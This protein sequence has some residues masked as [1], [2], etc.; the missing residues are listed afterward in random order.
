[1]FPRLKRTAVVQN[2]HC[3][4]C[5]ALCHLVHDV[6]QHPC[7]GCNLFS[8]EDSLACPAS[9]ICPMSWQHAVCSKAALVSL[10]GPWTF[11]AALPNSCQHAPGAATAFTSYGGE[12]C[13]LPQEELASRQPEDPAVFSLLARCIQNDTTLQWQFL[14]KKLKGFRELCGKSNKAVDCGSQAAAA[15]CLSHCFHLPSISCIQPCLFKFALPHRADE[16]FR[17]AD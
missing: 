3:K 17:V 10:Q 7:E 4:Q 12:D 1:M 6:P 16:L 5:R 2:V 14:G 13:F 9:H 8:P 11:G 15:E